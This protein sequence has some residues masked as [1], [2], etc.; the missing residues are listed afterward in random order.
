MAMIAAMK[1]VLS[2]N[3][4]T[5][6]T[7]MEATKAWRKPTFPLLD[8]SSDTGFT[9]WGGDAFCKAQKKKTDKQRNKKNKIKSVGQ[10]VERAKL[11]GFAMKTLF[12]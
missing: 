12:I 2:P 1:K 5:M 10:V 6:M 4:D 11:A 9:G 7:E 8:S 3:S